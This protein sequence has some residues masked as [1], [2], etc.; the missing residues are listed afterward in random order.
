M[1]TS[2]DDKVSSKI[3]KTANKLGNKAKQATKQ[4]TSSNRKQKAIL[5]PKAPTTKKEEGESIVTF[6]A[7]ASLFLTGVTACNSLLTIYILQYYNMGWQV[8][9]FCWIIAKG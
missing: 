7:V 2:G 8:R 5:G 1:L 9:F 6:V 3:S 4:G